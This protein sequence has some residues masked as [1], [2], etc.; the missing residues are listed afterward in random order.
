VRGLALVALLA[1]CAPPVGLYRART[2]APS[3]SQLT[4]G[5]EAGL[6]TPETSD[7][8]AK[9]P[10]LNLSA[11]YRR[12]VADR[13]ELGGR[14]MLLGFRG[15]SALGVAGDVKVQLRRSEDP[16]SGTD[17]A[18]GAVLAYQQVRLGGTPW[19]LS[20]IAL[21]LLIG[22]NFG[23]HQLVWGPRVA[24]ELWTGEGQ[25][26]IHLFYGGGSVAFAWRVGESLE[27]VPELAVLYSPIKLGGEVASEERTGATITQLTLGA[28]W[29][30]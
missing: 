11:G 8:D 27:L 5:I 16:G 1:A 29:R 12:G 24:Y 18:T 25:D 21:P 15:F 6:V 3:A 17:V 30:F 13:V 22:H 4:G 19:H 2:L 10:W 28:C 26:P 9:L 23:R 14:V 7:G 20:S